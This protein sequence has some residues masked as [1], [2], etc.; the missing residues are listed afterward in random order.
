MVELVSTA[1]YLVRGFPRAFAECHRWAKRVTT[2]SVWDLALGYF[3]LPGSGI[4]RACVA[5]REESLVE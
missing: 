5:L 4:H 1:R 2:I 3:V